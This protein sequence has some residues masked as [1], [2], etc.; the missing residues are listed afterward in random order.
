MCLI[1]PLSLFVCV[2]LTSSAVV[3][4]LSYPPQ[5][6]LPVLAYVSLPPVYCLCLFIFAFLSVFVCVFVFIT[7]SRTLLSPLPLASP[8]SSLTSWLLVTLCVGLLCMLLLI[9]ALS[10]TGTETL[11]RCRLLLYLRS[12]YFISFFFCC[13]RLPISV[14]L[15]LPRVCTLPRLPLS[16][17]I[18][19]SPASCLFISLCL[20]RGLLS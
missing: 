2:I 4:F 16:S 14:S 3:V 7:A 5:L 15:S 18:F 8:P 9:L 10:G 17:Q 1:L 13:V 6:S 12:F 11:N 19:L 20:S